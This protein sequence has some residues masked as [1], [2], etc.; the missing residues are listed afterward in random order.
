MKISS[1]HTVKFWAIIWSDYDSN[2]K[3]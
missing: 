2:F 3:L 1:L